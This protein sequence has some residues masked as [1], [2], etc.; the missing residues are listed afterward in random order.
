MATSGEK[1][2]ELL[3]KVVMALVF[4]GAFAFTGCESDDIVGPE[5]IARID[6]SPDTASIEVGESIDFSVVALNA[7]GDT[8]QNP[9]IRWWSTNPDVFTVEDDGV[10]TGQEPGEAFCNIE[11][12]GRRA[13]V[14]RDSAFVLVF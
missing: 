11:V 10:A 8:I 2:Q 14:G 7:S 6:I 4:A 12:T 3:G 1:L 13:F 5:E 9:D